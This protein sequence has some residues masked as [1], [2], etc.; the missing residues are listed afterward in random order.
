MPRFMFPIMIL[1]AVV[2]GACSS[3]R[4]HVTHS[5]QTLPMWNES[6]AGEVL[7]PVAA[8]EGGFL[9][10]EC[11]KAAEGSLWV[12]I[13]QTREMG[14]NAI[15]DVKWLPKRSK[16]P[17]EYPACKRK[18]GFALVWPVTLTP[19]FMSTRVEG[20][21][22]RVEDVAAAE[23]AGLFFVPPSDDEQQVLVERMLAAKTP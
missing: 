12:L 13:Q 21:A 6:L 23:S 8:N 14:G 9:W 2:A 10:T 18:W 3:H 20:V 7:G 1:L 5:T 19:A 11:T 4:A 17:L 15:G 16:G 22:Y